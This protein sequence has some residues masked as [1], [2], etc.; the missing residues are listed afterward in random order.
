LRQLIRMWRERAQFMLHLQQVSAMVKLDSYQRRDACEICGKTLEMIALVV[1]PI[2]T[3]LHLASLYR[4]QRDMSP[5]WNTPLWKHF[6]QTFTPTC[7]LCEDCAKF[8]HKRNTNI[9]VNEK[10]FQR[11]QVKKK[12][13]YELMRRSEYPLI[14]LDNDMVTLLNLWLGW[15]RALANDENPVEFL[16]RFGFEGRSAAQVRR[17]MIMAQAKEEEDSLPSLSGD[18]EPEPGKVEEE[19]VKDPLKID[20]NADDL[21][22]PYPLRVP[23]SLQWH[24]KSIMLSWLRRAQQGLQAPQMTH[25]A[26]ITGTG[27]SQAASSSQ[28]ADQQGPEDDAGRRV[29]ISQEDEVGS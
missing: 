23:K 18:E 1:Q 24:E 8:Y 19:D 14:P 17:D 20:M 3:L 26:N 13:A 9:P 5:L 15:T 2:Y 7:T 29:R 12:T 21:K 10:R 4:E 27:Q 28:T 11:L 22:N 6:Y 16:P 25:W